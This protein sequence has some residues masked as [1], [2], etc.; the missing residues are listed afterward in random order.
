MNDV[1]IFILDDDMDEAEQIGMVLHENGF[2]NYRIFTASIPMLQ[3]IDPAARIFI[4]DYRVDK[5]NGLEVIEKIKQ[6]VP[7]C[8][9]IMLSGM[10]N[11]EIIEQFDNAVMRGK[12]IT[13]GK[14]DTETRIIKFIREFI[15]DMKIMQAFYDA[16]DTIDNN[17]KDIRK[18]MKGGEK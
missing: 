1:L 16:K 14:A 15:E 5:L 10:R 18:I 17:I 2:P 9:F 7:H 13:K 6:I 4:V 11:Y 12:Y 3:N 8:Y